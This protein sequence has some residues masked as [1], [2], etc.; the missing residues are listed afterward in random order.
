MTRDA[1]GQELELG[2]KV[3]FVGQHYGKPT[4]NFG[5]VLELAE[6]KVCVF[7]TLRRMYAEHGGWPDEDRSKVWVETWKVARLAD[8]TVF[9]WEEDAA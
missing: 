4:I 9:T 8:Q 5:E 2:D 6:D 1:I 7:R 3:V